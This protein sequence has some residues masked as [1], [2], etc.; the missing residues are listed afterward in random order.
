MRTLAAVATVPG[1]AF[2][3]RD[4]ELEAPRDEEV[5]I[6][7]VG[8]GICHTDLIARDQVIPTPLPAVFGHEASGIVERVGAAVD[9]LSVGDTVVLTF[10]SCGS[11]GACRDDRPAYCAQMPLLN[12]M[13]RRSDGSTALSDGATPISSHFFGQSSFATHALAHRRNAIKVEVGA[14]P[15]EYLGPLGCGIQT[16]AGTVMRVLDSGPSHSVAVFG[17][18][19]VGMS[20]VLAAAARGCRRIILIEPHEARRALAVELGATDVVDPAAVAEV[21]AAVRAI[22]PAGI[23]HVVEATGIPAVI[24]AAVAST[25]KLGTCALVGAPSKPGETAPLRFGLVV[26]NGVTLRGVIEGDSDPQT[27]IPELLRLQ[28]AGRFPFERMIAL[29]ELTDINRAIEKQKAGTCLKAVLR[30]PRTDG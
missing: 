13:G 26:Q 2:Q 1:E 22:E 9:D 17:G 21:A 14:L 24:E 23:D 18:G 12:F 7:I 6:R 16:G 28:A 27:F 25:A 3:L 5:L 20:A 19:P 30:M 15:L 29:Y 10:L 8:T 4:L 11:C